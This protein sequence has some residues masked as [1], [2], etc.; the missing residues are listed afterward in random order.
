MIDYL[1][2]NDWLIIGKGN[3]TDINH[4]NS[5]HLVSIY[6]GGAMRRRNLICFWTTGLLLVKEIVLISTRQF[7]ALSEHLFWWGNEKEES[8]PTS[9]VWSHQLFLFSY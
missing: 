2:L 6:F 7:P 4:D 5:L 3:S 9:V 8:R 1:L